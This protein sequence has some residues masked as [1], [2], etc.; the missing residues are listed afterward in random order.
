MVLRRCSFRLIND[1]YEDEPIMLKNL[2]VVC[3]ASLM[4]LAVI[5]CGKNET[6]PAPTTTDAP[7]GDAPVLT[8]PTGE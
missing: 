4:C 7:S 3:V 5:G 1:L 2:I 6:P 8:T